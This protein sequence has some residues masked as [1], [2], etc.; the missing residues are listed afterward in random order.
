[1]AISIKRMAF[2]LKII[3]PQLLSLPSIP[4]FNSSST[5]MKIVLI[6][7]FIG[8][9]SAQFRPQAPVPRNQPEVTIVRS[10]NE[11]NQGDGSFRWAYETSDGTRAEQAGYIKN[12]GAPQDD[13][14]QSLSGAYSHYSPE[15]EYLTVTYTADENGFVPQ[16]NH[17]PTPP[18]IPADIQKS[19]DIILR[20]AQ[21]Q[22]QRQQFRGK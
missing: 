4:P 1:M 22:Q 16:G 2:S 5:M 20:N 10:E 3:N 9:A 19:L 21:S 17:L 6:A 13:I 14:I 7:A 12:P 11:A 15:G 8:I 18:P